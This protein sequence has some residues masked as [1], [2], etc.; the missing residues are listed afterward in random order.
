[1]ITDLHHVGI[2]VRDLDAALALFRDALQ[3][4]CLKEG[5]VPSRGVR[6]AM[7]AAGRSYVEII[8]PTRDDS[9]SAAFLRERGEGLHHV[10]LCSTDIDADVAA[11]RDKDVPLIDEGP[12]AGFTGRLSYLDPAAFDGAQIE[13]VEPEAAFAGDNLTPGHITRID[14]VVF[15]VPHSLGFCGRMRDWF[16][17]E[18]KRT[19]ERG[20]MTFAFMRPGDVVMEVIGPTEPPAEPR[21]GYIAGLAFE[22]MGIDEL[23]ADLKAQGYPIG[24][25]HPALQ[26]GRIVS[27]H[28]SGAFGVPLAFI[29]FAGSPGPTK[30]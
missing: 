16:G 19:F 3:L 24:E 25:P 4:P 27:V 21:P 11:L 17:I 28:H 20:D 14:H 22:V 30:H 5:D 15:R 12:R 18:T 23:T 8:A 13:V 29:D 7:L 26:G 1:M 10:A 2:A 6:A 9:P